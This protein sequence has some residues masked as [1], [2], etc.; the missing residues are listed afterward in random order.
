V[1][2]R[3][4]FAIVMLVLPASASA[5]PLRV[6]QA[7]AGILPPRE[8]F[9]VLNSEGFDPLGQPVRRGPNYV[10]RAVDDTDREVNVVINARS[11][12]IVSV[13]PVRTASRMPPGVGLAPPDRVAPGYLPPRTYRGA[14]VVEDDEPIVRPPA[15][16]PQRPP[17]YV[18]RPPGYVP[19]VVDE[20]AP[21]VSGAVRSTELPPPAGQQQGLLPPPPERFPQRAAPATPLKPKPVQ[22]AAATPVK[23]TPLPK[24]KPAAMPAVVPP[25]AEGGAAPA[26]PLGKSEAD[27]AVPH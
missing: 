13:T 17:S 16:V 8:I 15:S 21:P 23:P 1:K 4:V 10:L 24:P 25:P 3:W 6:A 27:D 19:P 20:D 11:G 18:A 12:A 22:R 9:E 14:P 26:A 7:E 2:Q 5:E